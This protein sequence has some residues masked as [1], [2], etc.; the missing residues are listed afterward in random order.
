MKY[1]ISYDINL[2]KDKASYSEAHKRITE[3][4]E[5]MGAKWILYSVWLLETNQSTQSVTDALTSLLDKDDTILVAP[6][7]DQMRLEKGKR[8]DLPSFRIGPRP[9]ANSATP[10]VP[11][12]PRGPVIKPR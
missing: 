5:K 10:S 3:A 1:V 7:S 2:E 8:F 11:L 9:Q 12:R 4:L 6:T